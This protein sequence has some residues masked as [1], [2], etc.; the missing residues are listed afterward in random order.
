MVVSL[1]NDETHVVG[2][3][4]GMQGRERLFYLCIREDGIDVV[5]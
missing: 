2:D 3:E 4:G 1:S 5:I